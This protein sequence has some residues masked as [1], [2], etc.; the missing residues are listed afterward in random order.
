MGIPPMGLFTVHVGRYTCPI[1]L[2]VFTTTK[3]VGVG[4]KVL[5]PLEAEPLALD[6]ERGVAELTARER[7]VMGHILAGETN[8]ETG[9]RLGI[10]PRTVEVFRRRLMEKIGARN[11]AQLVRVLTLAGV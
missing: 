2:S 1:T 6:V 7:Q 11:T 3:G 5:R 9:L 8:K 10:S 4:S